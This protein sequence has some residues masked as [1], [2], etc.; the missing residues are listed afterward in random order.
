MIIFFRFCWYYLSAELMK[1]DINQPK[2]MMIYYDVPYW[3]FNSCHIKCLTK[4]QFDMIM[5]LL[6]VRGDA[7]FAKSNKM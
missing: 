4:I 5:L 1:F 7:V 6:C 3:S 2:V